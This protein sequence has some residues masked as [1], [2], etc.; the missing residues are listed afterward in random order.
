MYGNVGLFHGVH[1]N[2]YYDITHSFKVDSFTYHVLGL[3]KDRPSYGSTYYIFNCPDCTE[4][5]FNIVRLPRK[6]PH[7]ASKST[8]GTGRPRSCSVT[9]RKAESQMISIE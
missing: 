8:D 2:N 1:D 7:H 9:P 3:R 6:P 4:E 5:R